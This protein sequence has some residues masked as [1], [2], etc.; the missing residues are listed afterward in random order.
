MGIN[1]MHDANRDRINGITRIFQDVASRVS[2]RPCAGNNARYNLECGDMSPLWQR[3]HV[4]ALQNRP[5]TPMPNEIRLLTS[6]LRFPG[7]ALGTL[8]APSA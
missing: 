2:T 7:P 6:A 3:G 8:N 4:R 1:P 5:V